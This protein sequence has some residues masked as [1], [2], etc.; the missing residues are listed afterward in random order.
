M[1]SVYGF[2]AVNVEAQSRSPSSLLNWMK[3]LIAARRSRSAFGRGA[4]RFLYPSNRKVIA[5]LRSLDDEVILCV[6]NLSRSPQAVEL[7]L[8]EFRGR[9]PVELLGRSVFPTIGDLP[10]LLTLQ[11]HSF[12]WFELLSSTQ[13]AGNLQSSPPE[14]VTL[15]MPQGWADLFR[16]H[17]LVQL[18]SEIISLAMVSPSRTSAFPADP[19]EI[20]IYWFPSS[21]SV[22]MVATESCLIISCVDLPRS[23]TTITFSPGLWGNTMLLTVPL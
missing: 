7:D 6:A 11:A 17:N 10:Y 8:A 14:F 16:Q 18:E 20:A 2:E 12:F 9:Q 3:R 19:N 5:Y 15:V 4:L 22:S 21:P 23:I 1:D 13:E